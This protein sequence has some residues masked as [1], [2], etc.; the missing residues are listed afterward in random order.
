[1]TL[2]APDPGRAERVRARCHTQL[3]R[4]RQREERTAAIIGFA[5][6]VAAPLA[7]G[8]FCVFYAAVLVATTLRL[9][10]VFH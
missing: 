3:R 4:N 5:W 6:R 9:E 2:L 8:A 10:G 1:L 7:V